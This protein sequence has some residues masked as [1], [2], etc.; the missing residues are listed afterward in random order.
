M[1][2]VTRSVT[3]VAKTK[4]PKGVECREATTEVDESAKG[5][6]VS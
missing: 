3:S 1:K 6:R 4:P 5:G 2:R